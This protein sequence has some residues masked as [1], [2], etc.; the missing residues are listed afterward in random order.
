MQNSLQSRISRYYP[1]RK[2]A[3]G[4]TDRGLLEKGIEF[5][6][7]RLPRPG[8]FANCT[9]GLTLLGIKVGGKRE[10]GCFRP[11]FSQNGTDNSDLC[12]SS[13]P[14]YRQ[15]QL[16]ERRADVTKNKNYPV[17]NSV[18]DLSG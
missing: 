11:W 3:L 13:E 9:H 17:E 18:G 6:L 16:C 2:E 10:L 4:Q 12:S 15:T 14:N 1:S 8:D 7:G 5:R